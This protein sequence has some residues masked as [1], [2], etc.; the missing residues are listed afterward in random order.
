MELLQVLRQGEVIAGVT[1][2]YDSSVPA[3]RDSG[4]LE[5][6]DE[7]KKTGA[8][9]AAY[10]F[11]MDYLV[12]KSHP[13]VWF[14][15]SRSYLD[16]GVLNYK[17]KFRP[18]V[19]SGSDDYVLMRVRQLDEATRSMLC[20]SPCISWRDGQLQRTYFRD[21]QA[22]GQASGSKKKSKI[23]QFGLDAELI[24]DASGDSLQQV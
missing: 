23:W 24:Y 5:G 10:L 21:A 4:V 16:D 15:L 19:T 17:R 8:I 6:S 18:I 1:I 12:S 7:I 2:D 14:G 3:L 11:A 9:S 20:S 22:D 13:K